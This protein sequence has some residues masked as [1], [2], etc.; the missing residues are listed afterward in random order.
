MFMDLSV[1]AV[2]YVYDILRE[3]ERE[4]K[5]WIGNEIKV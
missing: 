2:S 4:R 5:L 3:R 1:G